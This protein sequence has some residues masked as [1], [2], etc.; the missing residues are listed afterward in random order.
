MANSCSKQTTWEIEGK[1][2]SS[3][4]QVEADYL[5]IAGEQERREKFLADPDALRAY[6]AE[7]EMSYGAISK[8]FSDNYEAAK[9][10]LARL[11]NIIDSDDFKA[12]RAAG[13]CAAVSPTRRQWALG[14]SDRGQLGST[15]QTWVYSSPSPRCRLAAESWSPSRCPQPDIY[16]YIYIHYFWTNP[17]T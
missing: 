5:R 7:R 9:V 16:I 10:Q 15:A 13:A 12:M 6:G 4:R 11:K 8:L 3:A 2:Y 17:G 1:V 14:G